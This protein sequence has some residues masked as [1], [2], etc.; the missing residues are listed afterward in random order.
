MSKTVTLDARKVIK[1]INEGAQSNIT[2]FEGLVG[3]MGERA[4]RNYRLVSLHNNSLLFEDVDNGSYYMAKHDRTKKNGK[5][6][7]TDISKVQIKESKKGHVFSN[8]CCDLIDAIAE[9]NDKSAESAFK[10]LEMCRFRPTVAT[11]EGYV[12]TRDNMRRRINIAEDVVSEDNKAKIINTILE[13]LSDKVEVKDGNIVSASLHDGTEIKLPITEMDRRR[14]IA[15]KMRLVAESA[16]QST[17]FQKFC[18]NVAGLV[19]QDKLKEAVTESA[20]F[21]GEY[22]EFCMLNL[23]EMRD[24]VSNAL[25]TQNNYNPV[26]CEHTALTLF[27]SNLRVNKND[28]LEAWGKT[29]KM[30]GSAPILEGVDKLR[31]ANNFEDDYMKFLQDV[32]TEDR[33]VQRKAFLNSLSVIRNTLEN[34]VGG[35]DE[36]VL[37]VDELMA[38]LANEDTADDSAMSEAAE[39]LASLDSSIIDLGSFDQAG[40]T[41]EIDFDAIGAGEEGMGE[42]GDIEEPDLGGGG[43]GIPDLGEP[44]LDLEPDLGELET[45]GEDLGDEGIEGAEGEEEEIDSD[46]DLEF[47]GEEEE[48]EEEELAAAEDISKP[49]TPVE[50]MDKDALKEEFSTWCESINVYIATHGIG[51]VAEDID[52]YIARC[53]ALNEDVLAEQF[54]TLM[55]SIEESADDPY[56]YDDN[57]AEIA[58]QY[59]ALVNEGDDSESDSDDAEDGEDGEEECEDGEH[60][61]DKE[62]D[63]NAVSEAQRK[64]PTNARKRTRPTTTKKSLMKEEGDWPDKVEKGDLRERMDLSTQKSLEDQTTPHDV[65]KFFDNTNE[66]GRGMVMFAV[67]SNKDDNEFWASVYDL[68]K[69]KSTKNEEVAV[70]VSDEDN[71]SSAIDAVFANMDD[72]EHVPPMPPIESPDEGM[73]IG[74]VEMDVGEVEME[75]DEEEVE[76]SKTSDEEAVIEDNDVMDPAKS[77]YKN[78]DAPR[79]WADG[80]SKNQ[81]PS[82]KKMSNPSSTTVKAPAK[83]TKPKFGKGPFRKMK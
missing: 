49:M 53:E 41:P 18:K 64:S 47:G 57:I 6:H 38:R 42:V 78:D 50:S 69:D 5:V 43:G 55:P 14:L 10:K 1:F 81:K 40:A 30:A 28:I 3:K 27:R 76:E 80:S 11:N 61:E 66:E 23:N 59:G 82:V 34:E 13:A 16:Y 25:A 12:V 21:L 52:R 73:D 74:E 32:M 51:K 62:S 79:K 7:L 31:T 2:M 4:G 24:L 46:L 8:A 36:S 44:G 45:G 70:V 71:L 65:A 48:E 15:K 35:D 20:K 63:G 33:D 83:S 68:I 75:E 17:S 77:S 60:C 22:Q 19:S 39:L 67:N 29:A 72:E 56:S 58:E 9:E 54:R 26:L 37:Q